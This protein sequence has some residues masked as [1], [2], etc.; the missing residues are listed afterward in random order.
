MNHGSDKDVHM[1][2]VTI[3][4]NMPD[5]LQRVCDAGHWLKS[6]LGQF[7]MSDIYFTRPI[8]G[9][10]ADY[11]NAVASGTTEMDSHTLEH[12]LKS[13][14]SDNGRDA[15]ARMKGIVPIDIDIIWIDTTCLRPKEITRYYYIKGARMLGLDVTQ[16]N[17]I[18]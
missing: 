18:L 9:S 3:G 2:V 8:S 17:H 14:E 5:S 12:I 11:A 4:S 10:G 15:E 13:Y 16:S 1:V 7:N 6:I